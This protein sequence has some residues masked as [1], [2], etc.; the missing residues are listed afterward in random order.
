MVFAPTPS[1]QVVSRRLALTTKQAAKGTGYYKGTRTG[2]Q[3]WHTIWGGY[4]IDLRKVR[5]YKAPENWKED[6]ETTEWTPFVGSYIKKADKVPVLKGERLPDERMFETME[7][8][9]GRGRLNGWRY[10]RLFREWF[11]A[12]GA[13]QPR[14]KE[15][16]D[17]AFVRSR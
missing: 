4:I 3:G 10:L 6:G 2:S 13:S 9:N 5:T 7:D 8:W 17:N 11:M 1:L 15:I 14:S 12:N 16:G